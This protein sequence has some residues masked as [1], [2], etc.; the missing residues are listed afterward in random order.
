MTDKKTLSEA[1]LKALTYFTVGVSSEGGFGGKDVSA[2]LSFAGHYRSGKMYPIENSGITIG[3]LQKDMGQDESKTAIA[4]VG[5]Y[6]AWAK[7]NHLR[8]AFTEAEQA[9]AI[10]DL[11]R[12][13]RTINGQQNRALDRTIKDRLDTFLQSEGGRNFVHER[14]R[15]QVNHIHEKALTNLIEKPMY[16]KASI[17]DQIKLATIVAK[18][19]NQSE[20]RGR[21][22]WQAMDPKLKVKPLAT[23]DEVQTFIDNS[24]NF[25][26]AMREGRDLALKGAAIYTQ[27]HHAAAK[28]P[29]HDA[30]QAVLD[31]PL[32][33][34]TEIGKDANRPHLAAQYT[35]IKNLFLQ[36]GAA[37]DFIEALEDGG[38]FQL[39]KAKSADRSHPAQKLSAASGFYVAGQDFVQWGVEG[40]VHAHIGGQWSVISREALTRSVQADRSVA[41]DIARDGHTATLLHV[42]VQSP[43]HRQAAEKPAAQQ[44]ASTSPSQAPQTRVQPAE[45]APAQTQGSATLVR[46]LQQQL[47]TLGVTDM[48]QQALQVTGIHDAATQT[49]V[50]RFQHQHGLPI[51]GHADE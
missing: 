25:S 24:K 22:L 40:Q 37:K 38:N 50:A 12:N 19:F 36:P 33:R 7:A 23:L 18:A 16:Q 5:A 48:D 9:S 44:P 21:E 3:M 41:L 31:D 49:A 2:K 42:P 39:P 26:K 30:W 10:S 11:S 4:L 14:D 15:S 35:T 29:L 47:N 34:P 6:Q 45:P 20:V 51:T 1:E 46:E 27:L 8:E 17:D 32:I 43:E 13:G 28:N